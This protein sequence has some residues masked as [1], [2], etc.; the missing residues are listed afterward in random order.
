MKCGSVWPIAKVEAVQFRSSDSL[1]LTFNIGVVFNGI[2]Q[3]PQPQ[4]LNIPKMDPEEQ[5]QGIGI[6]KGILCH[7]SS[8][9]YILLHHLNPQTPNVRA[10]VITYTIL[11]VPGCNSSIIYPKTLF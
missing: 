4:A 8:D 1:R 11:E 2:P 6:Y 7:I 5:E 9:S 10:S 3:N